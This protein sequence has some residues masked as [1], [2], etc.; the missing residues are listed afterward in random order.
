[1]ALKP[2]QTELQ[3]NTI[4]AVAASGEGGEQILP[5]IEVIGG[6]VTIYGS[7]DLPANAPTGM[8]EDQTSFSGIDFFAVVPNYIYIEQDSGTTTSII[9]SG[10]SV[11]E[12][13]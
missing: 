8:I 1:M 12:V 2:Y 5:N 10:L 6:A 9:V 3:L 13:E 7:Q 4:Y 11:T